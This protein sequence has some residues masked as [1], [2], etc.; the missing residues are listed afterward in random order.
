M[1]AVILAGGFGTR[2][3]S[4]VPGIPKPL[5]P[6]AG[7]PFLDHLL[8]RLARQGVTSATLCLHY[9]A[10]QIVDYFT[11]HPPALKLDFRIE[12]IPLGTGGALAEF[13]A[14][15]KEDGP[16]LVL[17]GDSLFDIDCNALWQFHLGKASD[18]TMAVRAAEDTGRYGRVS[19]TGDRIIGFE[20]ERAGQ[21]GCINAG[22]YV[23]TPRVFSGA[24]LPPS[25]SLERDFLP[26]YVTTRTAHAW[27]GEG[28]FID[29]GLPDDY[30]RACR[31]LG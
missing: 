15:A 4:A 9:E 29:I 16:F 20:P 19:L 11:A 21:P 13:C 27:V 1:W 7:R 2:L 25:F 17:N 24:S 8:A 31:D 3:Q 22:I 30:A 5:A 10:G 12:E 23:M 26:S 28:Y 18:F 14:S 6:V